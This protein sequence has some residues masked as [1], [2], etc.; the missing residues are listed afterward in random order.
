MPRRRRRRNRQVAE[1]GSQGNKYVVPTAARARQFLPPHAGLFGMGSAQTSALR[2]RILK[3]DHKVLRNVAESLWIINSIINVRNDQLRPFTKRL[4]KG[5]RRGFKI[6]PLDTSVDEE[7][8]SDDLERLTVFFEKTGFEPD[9]ER[10]DDFAD[11]CQMILRDLFTVDQVAVEIHYNKRGN[12]IAFTVLDGTTIKRLDPESEEYKKE[13]EGF[14]FIQDIDD[15]FYQLFTHD[16]MIFDYFYKRSELQ[17]RGY[18]YS[19]VEQCIDLLTTLLFGHVFSRDQF[20]KNKVPQG[21][22]EVMGDVGRE[23]LDTISENWVSTLEGAGGQFAVPVL[24][25]GK[26][27]V[28]VKFN[29]LTQKNREME[30]SKLMH[31]LISIICAVFSIDPAEMGIKSDDSNNLAEA[32]LDTRQ[33]SSRDRGLSALL[34]FI[35]QICN[36]VLQRVTDKYAFIFVGHDLEE[37]QKRADV[38]KAR[39]EA[40]STVDEEREREGLEPFGE[41]WSEMV[42]NTSLIQMRTSQEQAA[43]AAEMEGEGEE[44]D[45][46]GYDEDEDDEVIE[47]EDEDDEDDVREVQKSLLKFKQLSRA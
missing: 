30:Y 37:D 21:Y 39:L 1:G 31:F 5:Q 28:G 17:Y 47:P 20:Q 12:P 36:K 46:Y 26:D 44:D 10:E 7:D 32:S 2:Q 24:P 6:V 3:I 11:F 25:S 16:T 33:G 45:D 18:G 23:Q 29:Q 15:K 40:F 13:Y 35:E 22:I 27:G 9:E 41:D 42:A 8:V 14:A 4:V 19:P 38:A 43:Q 34:A